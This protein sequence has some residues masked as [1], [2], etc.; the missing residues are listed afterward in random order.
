MPT[1][2]LPSKP[3]ASVAYE[4]FQGDAASNLLIVCL[5]G[6][7][8]PQ[9]G[10]KP[11][12]ELFQQQSSVSPKPWILTYDRYGQGA[13]SRDP[14]EGWPNKEPGYTHTLDD[15]TDDLHELIQ[16]LCADRSSRIVFLNNSIGAH[17]ARRYAD[18]YPTIVE[19]ILFLDSNPGNTDFASIWPNPKDPSFDLEKMAPP[20]TSLEVYE[21]AYAKVTTIF[22]PDAKNKEG[23]DRRQIKNILPDP[24]KP[25]LKGSKTSEKGPWVTVVGHELE[26]FSKE[27]W[28][29]MKVPIG[30]A[31]MYT[32]PM[33][34]KYNE[35]LCGLTDPDRA[36]GPLIA[37]HS[38]H[39]VQRDNPAFVA[40]QLEDL[41][42][43]VES[44]T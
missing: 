29:T 28:T 40:E 2:T 30:M 8:L 25:K 17:V 36:K 35:G 37:P 6:L 9:G 42:R 41:I 33:W 32:Q 24:S 5:N 34:Q 16:T 7:G 43:K 10:W 44:A 4:L 13:S 23:F 26:Q 22:A 19:G 15:V 27:E 39:F 12:I 3:D 18:R 14:R 20:S 11:T 31:A 38:G 21:A 1:V